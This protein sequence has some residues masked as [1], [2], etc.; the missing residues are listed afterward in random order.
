M[1]TN[2]ATRT[3]LTKKSYDHGMDLH[4]GV[5][6][7]REILERQHHEEGQHRLDIPQLLRQLVAEELPADHPVTKMISVVR[8]AIEASGGK[9]RMTAVIRIR[10]SG[11]RWTNSTICARA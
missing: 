5:H 7:L 11:R 4:P 9:L 10:T 3:K 1:T 8:I 2:A 6:E